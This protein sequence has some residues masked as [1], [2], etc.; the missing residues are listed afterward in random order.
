[1]PSISP[2]SFTLR[3]LFLICVASTSFSSSIYAQDLTADQVSTVK[4]RL[5]E[6]A[7][8]SWELGTR[9][10]ALTEYDSPSYS[11][12]NGTKV[13][14]PT[15]SPPGSLDEVFNITK[16]VLEAR[17]KAFAN[18]TGP[19]PLV[20]ND[21]SS[22]D[23]ASIGVAVLLANW[24]GQGSTDGVDYAGAAQSQLEYLLTQVPR[25]SDG[26]I[27]HRVSEVQLWS[28]FVY[29]VPPFLAYYGVLSN[30]QSLVSEAYNQV[31]LYRQ[32]LGDSSAG[33]I[34]KH[35]VMGSTVPPDPGHWSTGNGW[36]AAGMLRVQGTIQNSP[37]PNNFK[38]EMS[39]LSNWVTEILN[40]MYPH[41]RSDQLFLNYADNNSTFSDAASTALLASAAYRH[42]LL[43]KVHTQLPNA[44][45]SRLAL[46]SPTNSSNSSLGHFDQNMWLTPVVN[47][48][49]FGIQGSESPE[50]QAF[51]VEM[52]AAWGDWV[53]AG[54]PGASSGTQV[55]ASVGSLSLALLAVIYSVIR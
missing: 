2:P 53:R 39:D 9:A 50:A 24:T 45:R 13:P 34:W 31:K 42:A 28:D 38:T 3:R 8:Q 21:G 51:V 1:M 19:Q 36:A 5:Q 44:E 14:P 23:P 10:Q 52:Q 26:A 22:A 17:T 29:M 15:S 4:Q 33:G 41:L 6:G 55:R 11:V 20:A 18:V 35:I 40:G 16:T 25:T 48:H 47:P 49:Q 27:S 30:N 54:S 46:V 32:Y 37:F 43:N 7:Q 12:T